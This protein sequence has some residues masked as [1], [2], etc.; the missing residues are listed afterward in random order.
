MFMCGDQCVGCDGL[1]VE[2]C[3]C[4]RST[5]GVQVPPT[6][7]QVC[8]RLQHQAPVVLMVG[9]SIMRDTWTAGA[10]W[11]LMPELPPIT[12]CMF[13]AW[14]FVEPAIHAAKRAGLL[15]EVLTPTQ[16]VST[17]HVCGRR[18]RLIFRYGRLFSDLPAVR[19]EMLAQGASA[20]VITHGILEM[21]SQ[22]LEEWAWGLSRL[23]YPVLYLSTHSRITAL[24]PPE[25]MQVAQGAQ[26]NA[27]IRKY[28]DTVRAL[29]VRVVDCYHL[30]ADLTPSYRDTMDGLH[31]GGWINAQRFW[32][33]V[34]AL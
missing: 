27:M 5:W 20:L 13:A 7:A 4:P 10:L 22:G 26:G 30:T 6:R 1:G 12:S 9:D 18:V 32:Q 15:T 3:D 8:A 11:L 25:F 33:M 29:G 16:S 28:A 19:E 23:P 21:G 2:G 31:F 24:T 17:F 34:A 14:Q